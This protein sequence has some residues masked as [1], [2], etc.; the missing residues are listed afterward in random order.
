MKGSP[1]KLFS[2]GFEAKD[3]WEEARRYFNPFGRWSS[4]HMIHKTFYIEDKFGMLIDFRS[5]AGQAMHGSGLQLMNAED[6]IQLELKRHLMGTGNV[7]C[8]VFVIS[9][10]QLNIKERKFQSVQ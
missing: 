5:M 4:P 6:G 2:D 3:F 9:D 10:S 7:N 1:N 8:H